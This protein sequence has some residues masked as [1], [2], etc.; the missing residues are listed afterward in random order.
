AW[1]ALP[2]ELED[3]EPD[4]SHYSSDTI[5]NIDLENVKVRVVAGSFLGSTSPVKVHSELVYVDIEMKDNSNFSF[6]TNEN[7][8]GLYIV[9]GKIKFE[10]NEYSGNVM[11]VFKN[12]S[13]IN[14]EAIGDVRAVIVGGKAFPEPRYLYWNFVSTSKEKLEEAKDRWRKQNFPK[15]EGETEFVTMPEY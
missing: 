5:P 3:I 9:S 13:E 8:L 15:I 6:N 2:K 10:D 14:I 12:G 11:L 1:V 4:F 7:E